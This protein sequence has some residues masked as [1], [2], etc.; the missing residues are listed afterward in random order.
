MSEDKL[1]Q[2]DIDTAVEH[3]VCVS[4]RCVEC[5]KDIDDCD[6]FCEECD[7]VGTIETSEDKW[8]YATDSHYT[9]DRTEECPSCDGT[10]KKKHDE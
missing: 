6:C 2:D 1:S 5:K 10:G 7:G 9:I 8:N 4:I 3:D